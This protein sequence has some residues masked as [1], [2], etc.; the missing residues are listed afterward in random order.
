M[1]PQDKRTSLPLSTTLRVN[2]ESLG[3]RHRAAL[4]IS[5]QA[6]VISIIVS[7]ETGS[8]SIAEN[9]TLTQGLSKDA[10]KKRIESAFKTPALKG[11]KA[12]ID[13]I[14]HHK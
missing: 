10:L 1:R 6:D 8:I 11:W 14:K 2:N 7:E 13:Q 12:F 5:E 9:G 4:G 3:M